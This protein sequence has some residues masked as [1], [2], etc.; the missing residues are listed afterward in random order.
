MSNQSESWLSVTV[1]GFENLYLVSSYGRVISCRLD[2]VMSQG[3]NPKGYRFVTLYKDGKHKMMLVHRLVAMAFIN[4]IPEGMEVNHKNGIKDDNRL[5]NLE[6]VTRSEN[7]IHAHTVLGSKMAKG[8]K[9]WASKFTE[10]QAMEVIKLL[11]DGIPP[12]E[13]AD[14]FSVH[15]DTITDIRDCR[16]WKHIPRPDLMPV[17]EKSAL[18]EVARLRKEN[19]E[20]IRQ[21]DLLKELYP[22][23]YAELE[24][25]RN[26]Q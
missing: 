20:L 5:E 18:K 25:K 10:S 19:A 1:K 23:I 3:K 11:V 16:T 4:G 6:I 22:E 21:L 24:H 15:K 8:G 13:I 14:M 17:G 26:E 7:M 12:Q 9:H 2:K